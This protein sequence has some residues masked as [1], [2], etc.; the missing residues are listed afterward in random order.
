MDS[1]YFCGAVCSYDDFC[2]GCDCP[3]C[4]RCDQTMP[5]GRHCVEDHRSRF[6]VGSYDVILTLE[7]TADG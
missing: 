3:V 2:P 1:C 5:L 7:E 6:P 4:E